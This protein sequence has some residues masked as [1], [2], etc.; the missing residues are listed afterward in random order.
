MHGAVG[1]RVV[2]LTA[3][4]TKTARTVAHDNVGWELCYDAQMRCRI[5]LLVILPWCVILKRY[6]RLRG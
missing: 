1:D 5:L 4:G 3:I 2:L 6:V